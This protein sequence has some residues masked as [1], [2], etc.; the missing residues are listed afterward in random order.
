M[1]RKNIVIILLI[2]IL[3][4]TAFSAYPQ[5]T[6][7]SPGGSFTVEVSLPNTDLNRLP[8]YRNAITSL[9]SVGDYVIGGTTAREGLSPFVFIVSLKEKEMI[10]SIDISDIVSGQMAIK[11]GFTKGN[12]RQLFAGTIPQESDTVGGHLIMVNLDKNGKIKIN[13]LGVP[14]SHEGIF[15]MTS[16]KDHSRL[17]GLS[18]PSGYLFSF[19]VK[20]GKVKLFKEIAPDDRT[21]DY[22]KE[23]FSIEPEDYLSRDLV[24]DDNGIL[25]GSLPYGKIF[26]FD[27]K[28]EIFGELNVTLPYVW[29][30]SSIG[31]VDSWLKTNDGRIYGGNRADGQLFELDPSTGKIKNLGKPIA[32]KGLAG[33]TIGRDG[34]IYGIAGGKPGYSHLFSYHPSMGFKDYGNPQFEM[35]APGIEQG[36]NWRGFQLGTIASSENGRY[37]ILGENEA[38]SQLL[39]FPV[40]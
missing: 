38:L 7:F 28:R 22:L 29:G 31:Q 33:L 20:T 30:R 1:K 3:G 26:T 10:T 14:V 39:V 35:I 32:M 25:Y 15:S 2:A 18:Y 34:K 12:K 40:K 8:M 36:I 17:Y 13:D 19:D 37:I 24:I 5:Y 6:F 9:T 4:L 11:T 21:I 27:T 16:S 23:H